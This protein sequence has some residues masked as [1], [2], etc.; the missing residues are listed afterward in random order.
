[1]WIKTPWLGA[2][3]LVLVKTTE[4]LHMVTK[5]GCPAELKS[6]FCLCSSTFAPFP[7]NV[8]KGSWNWQ[9]TPLRSHKQKLRTN[10]VY[11]P[12]LALLGPH[13]GTDDTFPC[14]LFMPFL[15]VAPELPQCIQQYF[16][17]AGSAASTNLAGKCSFYP[18]PTT[19]LSL[20]R[21]PEQNFSSI[22]DSLSE[23]PIHTWSL[24]Y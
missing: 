11:V 4:F 19:V 20:P 3:V 14:L 12:F 2:C 9:T 21:I 5:Q 17:D 6:Q 7:S 22:T 23:Q 1:M 13:R 24:G 8:R 10:V 18:G 16:P 15:S